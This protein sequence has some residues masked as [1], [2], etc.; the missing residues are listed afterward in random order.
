MKS[1]AGS[2]LAIGLI[3][4]GC[5]RW[6][7]EPQPLAAAPAAP[8][9][10]NPAIESSRTMA[11]IHAYVRKISK[12]TAP[13]FKDHAEEIAWLSTQLE[14]KGVLDLSGSKND[15]QPLLNLLP[16]AELSGIET[17]IARR[18]AV[19]LSALSD[20]SLAIGLRELDLS[21]YRGKPID[22]EALASL[23]PEL[24][25]LTLDD[26]GLDSDEQIKLETLS[27][28][29]TL[30]LRKNKLTRIPYSL[31]KSLTVLNL[32][33]NGITGPFDQEILRF[34]ALETLNLAHNNLRSLK[35]DPGALGS[36]FPESLFS[37]N[38][39]ANPELGAKLVIDHVVEEKQAKRLNSLLDF[40]LDENLIKYAKKVATDKQNKQEEPKL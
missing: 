14:E 22:F 6:D 2:L 32:E 37:L 36:V 9:A 20:I 5:S 34:Q 15:T 30:S 39:L 10:P 25:V 13:T 38:I 17:L 12:E 27:S 23:F 16:V 33:K 3:L 31:P 21:E 19:D 28:L 11:R 4:L 8:S 18:N 35:S 29:T 7:R 26:C 24:E 40:P 1:N